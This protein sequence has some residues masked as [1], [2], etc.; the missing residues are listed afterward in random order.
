MAFSSGKYPPVRLSDIDG[1]VPENVLDSSSGNKLIEYIRNQDGKS[2]RP[3]L[4]VLFDDDDNQIRFEFDKLQAPTSPKSPL[5][6][7]PA[8]VSGSDAH[9][10][11]LV[12]ATEAPPESNALFTILRNENRVPSFLSPRRNSGTGQQ[13][14]RSPSTVVT[15]PGRGSPFRSRIQSSRIASDL[16]RL[17][18]LKE[19]QRANDLKCEQL[20]QMASSTPITG[21]KQQ[22]RGINGFMSLSKSIS[23]IPELSPTEMDAPDRQAPQQGARSPAPASPHRHSPAPVSPHRYSS[24][25]ATSQRHPPPPVSPQRRISCVVPATQDQADG[26]PAQPNDVFSSP[27]RV[28]QVFLI[29]ETPSPVHGSQHPIST[30][31]SGLR[32]SRRSSSPRSAVRRTLLVEERNDRSSTPLRS[33][34]KRESDTS[35]DTSIKHVSFAEHMNEVRQMSPAYA[36][37]PMSFYITSDE[38]EEEEHHQADVILKSPEKRSSRSTATQARKSLG[39]VKAADRYEE[40]PVE[41]RVQPAAAGELQA[42]VSDREE[43]SRANMVQSPDASRPCIETEDNRSPESHAYPEPPESPIANIVPRSDANTIER[44]IG[45]S[46]ETVRAGNRTNRNTINMIMEEWDTEELPSTN[47]ADRLTVDRRAQRSTSPNTEPIP[48]TNIDTPRPLLHEILDPPSEFC[49]EIDAPAPDAGPAIGTS[50]I[51]NDVPPSRDGASSSGISS[52]GSSTTESHAMEAEDNGAVASVPFNAAVRIMS[53]NSPQDHI[54]MNML[55]A[56]DEIHS[57][58]HSQVAKGVAPKG[59]SGGERR[60]LVMPRKRSTLAAVNPDAVSYFK[61]IENTCAPKLSKKIKA[62]KQRR[63]LFIKENPAADLGGEIDEEPSELPSSPP[64]ASEQSRVPKSEREPE[65]LT[66]HA[67]EDASSLLIACPPVAVCLQ[68]LSNGTIER[69]IGVETVATCTNLP[70]VVDPEPPVVDPEPPVVDPEPPV[71]LLDSPPVMEK[72]NVESPEKSSMTSKP[73]KRVKTAKVA[74]PRKKKVRSDETRQLKQLKD[75]ANGIRQQVEGTNSEDDPLVPVLEEGVRRSHRNRRL[76]KD[77]L[78]RNPIMMQTDMP[79]YRDPTF[80]DVLRYYREV[81]TASEKAPKQPKAPRGAPHKTAKT[82]PQREQPSAPSEPVQQK[83]RKQTQKQHRAANEFDEDGFRIPLPPATPSSSPS[84]TIS[85]S[86]SKPGK[87][88]PQPPSSSTL[89]SHMGGS[90]NGFSLDSGLSSAGYVSPTGDEM[91]NPRA[92]KVAPRTHDAALPSTSSKPAQRYNVSV[93]EGSTPEDIMAE[94][95]RVLDWMMFL[96]ESQK[97]RPT[98]TPAP[99]KPGFRH[100][101]VEHLMFDRSGDIEYSFYSCSVTDNFGFIRMLPNA[102]KKVSRAKGCILRFLILNGKA[103]FTINNIDATAVGGDFFVLP[104][105]TRYQI[106]NSSETSLMFMMKTAVPAD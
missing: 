54:S 36:R 20:R 50:H 39:N 5:K 105:G 8:S 10:E 99:E 104:A 102:K 51:N 88:R 101:S 38:S 71:M 90:P 25:P 106:Q 68:R 61:A 76:A 6:I 66:T 87:E 96:T 30:P 64:L 23:P 3:R 22:D 55:A 35:S 43:E 85:S 48:I 70:A 82:A 11:G 86:S 92:G 52:D 12:V 45:Q 17:A 57:S 69:M 27:P 89:L 9:S 97:E 72:Q 28:E 31:L 65:P 18:L 73:V 98:N 93:Q 67:I 46:F 83:G 75:V 78:K 7:P 79:N 84:S 103:K 33:I 2:R 74:E 19:C 63:K 13:Q 14:V 91:D 95:R 59:A 53:V 94:R 49:D 40:A 81:Q 16:N 21:Q 1:L 24:G 47:G 37:S 32:L 60:T 44:P 42:I 29:P 26:L 15:S 4:N 58:Q 100:F 56:V 62:G 80:K 77:V 41:V 34:L